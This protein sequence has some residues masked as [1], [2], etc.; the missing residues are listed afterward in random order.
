MSF[1]LD[2]LSWRSHCNTIR[3][4]Y[5]FI[6]STKVQYD[7]ITV[8]V[9]TEARNRISISKIGVGN[10]FIRRIIGIMDT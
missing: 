7:N 2:I 1:F 4:G 10:E 9:Y 6:Y 8:V 3:L 5:F